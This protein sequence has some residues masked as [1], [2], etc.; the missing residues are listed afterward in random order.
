MQASSFIEFLSERNMGF[1]SQIS[2]ESAFGLSGLFSSR[3]KKD[4]KCILI[5]FDPPLGYPPFVFE[6]GESDVLYLKDPKLEADFYKQ[7]DEAIAV[8]EHP[9]IVFLERK[10]PPHMRKIQRWIK[11]FRETVYKNRPISEEPK[12]I[13]AEYKAP[14]Y[15]LDISEIKAEI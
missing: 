9:I 13:L 11:N 7:V 14:L 4:Q 5:S 15:P 12:F 1:I 6:W 10:N 3:N 2:S 8:A